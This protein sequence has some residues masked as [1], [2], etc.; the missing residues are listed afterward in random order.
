MLFCE[1]ILMKNIYLLLCAKNHSSPSA[2]Y[3]TVSS[4]GHFRCRWKF[5]P[6]Y[7][8][9]PK[10]LLNFATCLMILREKFGV[11]NCKRVDSLF[12]FDHWLQTVSFSE[13]TEWYN[14]AFEVRWRG[15]RKFFQSNNPSQRLYSKRL[16]NRIVK[17]G[18]LFLNDKTGKDST[19]DDK[20]RCL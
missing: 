17:A 15:K 7:R 9:V 8:D 10:K 14:E 16:Y 3:I 20:I 1:V 2:L 12:N 13:S 11:S 19:G 18:I 4:Q 5:A 6:T